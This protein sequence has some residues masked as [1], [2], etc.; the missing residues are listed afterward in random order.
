[1]S[2][3]SI[4]AT[5]L[6]LLSCACAT[7]QGESIRVLQEH[8]VSIQVPGKDPGTWHSSG[9]GVAVTLSKGQGILTAKHVT[10]DLIPGTPVQACSSIDQKDCIVLGPFTASETVGLRGDWKIYPVE[11]LP[12]TT[13]VVPTLGTVAVGD[14][15]RTVSYPYGN[16]SYDE[17]MV[18]ATSWDE[19]QNILVIKSMVVFGSSGG[20]IFNSEGHLVGIISSVPTLT[21]NGIR[22]PIIG[23]ALGVPVDTQMLVLTE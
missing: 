12:K 18:S 15:I 4:L 2:V 22:H 21:M 13:R 16:L 10:E 17:G 1:M 23:L 6:V 20:P 5:F 3:L 11:A 9:S 8:T 19:N 14:S 7:P